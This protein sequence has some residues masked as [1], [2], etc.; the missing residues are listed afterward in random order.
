M[1]N[2]IIKRNNKNNYSL[3]FFILLCALNN[4]KTPLGVSST[5]ASILTVL[6]LSFCF[7]CAIKVHKNR[8]LNKYLIGI[9]LVLILATYY[10]ISAVLQGRNLETPW[11]NKIVSH[12]FLLQFYLSLLPI[13]TFY[14]YTRIGKVTDSVL[15]FCFYLF[16][17]TS[18]VHFVETYI[19]RSELFGSEDIVNNY[20]YSFVPLIPLLFLTKMNDSLRQTMIFV[21]TLL[22]VSGMKRGA[23]LMAGILLILLFSRWFLRQKKKHVMT[24][25]LL[26][27][28]GLVF[29]TSFYND[30]TFFQDRVEATMEGYSS[31]RDEMYVE[32]FNYYL[33]NTSS[34]EFLFGKG[35]FATIEIFGQYAHNDWLEIALDM[36]VLGVVIYLIYW[37]LFVMEWRTY[38][39]SNTIIVFLGILITYF[40][41]S[42]FSMS[43]TSMDVP[44]CLCIS[45]CLAQNDY[46]KSIIRRK[47]THNAKH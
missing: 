41:K 45:Y 27:I 1:E 42:L 23:I 37:V 22:V 3:L 12:K 32:Y 25:F 44:A 47:K 29:L 2:I 17:F 11:G 33:N 20:S 15:K 9:D 5:V 7:V 6:E 30:S 39:D 43:I 24:F 35:T 21:L 13:Y 19:S 31:G 34:D 14:Y 46:T 28:L 40:L 10:G 26:L 4:I 18:I 8:G 38:K 36:G 16:F